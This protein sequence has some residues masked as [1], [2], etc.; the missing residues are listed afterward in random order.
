MWNLSPS[1]PTNAWGQSRVWLLSSSSSRGSRRSTVSA[2]PPPLQFT[3]NPPSFSSTRKNLPGAITDW[4]RRRF[5]AMIEKRAYPPHPPSALIGFSSSGSMM[6]RFLPVAL[7]TNTI[8]LSTGTFLNAP[9]RPPSTWTLSSSEPPGSAKMFQTA[10]SPLPSDT[11]AAGPSAARYTPSSVRSL[12]SP[13]WPSS[14]VNRVQSP[15]S[16]TSTPSAVALTYLPGCRVD[17]IT[18]SLSGIAKNCTIEPSP[19]TAIECSSPRR[20]LRPSPNTW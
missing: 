15:A 3:S 5:D 19:P 1:R 9:T 7:F 10:L 2:P 11:L 14:I 12:K 17:A 16:A 8:T 6:R 20:T 13:P 18:I 4:I